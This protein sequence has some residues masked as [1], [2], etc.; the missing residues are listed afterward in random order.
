MQHQIQELKGGGAAGG[1][2]RQLRAAL[3]D[4]AVNLLFERMKREVDSM[5][6]RL[7]ETQNELSAWKFT[8]DRCC[9]LA[10]G[11]LLRGA[12]AS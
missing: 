9:T 11:I 12:L 8:P 2:T 5:R 3:L 4:P 6:S 10:S 7:Q 1:W